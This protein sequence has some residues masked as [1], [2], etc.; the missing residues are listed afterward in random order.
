MFVTFFG[1][2]GGAQLAQAQT[3][4]IEITN[5]VVPNQV[6]QAHQGEVTATVYNTINQTFDDGYAQ[7]TDDMNEITCT[8]V[9]FSIDFEQELNITVTYEVADNATLGYHNVTFEIS[10]GE[11]S[12][13]FHQYELEVTPA[14]S[15]IS[16]TTGTVFLQNQAGLVIATI[17]NH[18]NKTRTVQL[19]LFGANF[20]NATEEVDLAPGINTVAF[21][22]QHEANHIYDFGM[23]LVNL[24]LSYQ[25][26]IIDSVV[27]AIPVDMQFLNKVFAIFLP[28][29]IFEALVIFYAF[30]KRRRISRSSG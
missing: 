21:T 17:E 29:I 19:D 7:F 16:L 10:I 13:L 18:V 4:P 23:S 22:I 14:A 1:P 28:I 26:A 27:A 12:F 8:L 30:R 11:Y 15:L 6:P 5:V 9:N 3:T 2:S 20:A 25:G 24:S